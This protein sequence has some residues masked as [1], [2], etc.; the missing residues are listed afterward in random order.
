M[1]RKKAGRRKP[2]GLVLECRCGA[3]ARVFELEKG[4]MAH[5][6]ACGTLT[7]F[8]NEDLLERVRY[9]GALCPHNP[10]RKPCPGGHT[11]WCLICR[12]RTFYRDNP[13]N[14]KT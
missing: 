14:A 11:S 4:Y 8:Q 7:F 10:E 1:A 12:V 6:A 9:G 5:C 2:I 13:G 3:K